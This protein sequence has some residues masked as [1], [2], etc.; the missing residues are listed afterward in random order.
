MKAW[1]SLRHIPLR[2]H[3]EGPMEEDVR[4][5]AEENPSVRVLPRLSRSE[6]FEVIKGARFL[7]WPSEGYNET[8][9]LI[10]IEAFACGVPVIAS[11]LGAMTEIVEDGN[12]GL[13][14]IAGDAA[15]LAA[16]VEWSWTHPEEMDAMGNRARAEY[17]AKYTAE[18]NYP[19]L[20]AIY[21]Q[22]QAAKS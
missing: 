1:K 15:D 21:R 17:Q 18:K 10:A 13:H 11:R 3:G 7:V 2:I 22:V 5:L 19:L 6:C 14:F 8:F 4:R 9:G 16:K 12:T 20:M